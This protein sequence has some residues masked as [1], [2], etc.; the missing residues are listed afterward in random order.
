MSVVDKY[1]GELLLARK[2]LREGLTIS[3]YDRIGKVLEKFEKE[4]KCP[5]RNMQ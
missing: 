4:E 2:D 5:R 1:K 3:A